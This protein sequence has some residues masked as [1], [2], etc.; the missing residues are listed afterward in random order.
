MIEDRY[1]LRQELVIDKII[2]F[3][4]LALRK[5]YFHPGERHDFWEL[6]YIDKG[7]IEIITDNN[8]CVFKQGECVFYKPNEFHMGKAHQA[9]GPNLIVISFEC[10]SPLMTF[11]EQKSFRFSDHERDLL[12]RVVE[13]G[14]R[15]FSP[16]VDSPRMRQPLRRE[17]ALV[18]SEQLIKNYLEI[19]LITLIRRG[20]SDQTEALSTPIRATTDHALLEQAIRYL[21]RHLAANLSLADISNA[22]H[23]SQARLKAL[24]K[25]YT[26]LTT[27]QYHNKLKIDTAKDLIREGASFTEIADR[28]GFS[29]LPHFSRNFK[30]A[31]DMSPTEY[32]KTVRSR[33]AHKQSPALRSDRPILP[34][35]IARI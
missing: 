13:E 33:L 8:H 9:I 6:V 18:G 16:P 17:G 2:T 11:F 12:C 14:N 20:S 24:F 23:V 27:M 15:A 29:S 10:D 1:L 19:L 34:I 35:E 21:E 30:Q 22:V 5:D 7:E 4:Y 31:T 3:F 28:L 26:G 32:A 25:E